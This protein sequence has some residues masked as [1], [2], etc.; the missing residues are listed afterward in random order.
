MEAHTQNPTTLRRAEDAAFRAPFASL[1]PAWVIQVVGTLVIATL[2]FG[3]VAAERDRGTVRTLA[4]AGVSARDLATG[5]LMASG[6]LV[7]GLTAAAVFTSVVAALGAGGVALPVGRML[8]LL[9]AYFAALLAFASLV[10]W[11]SARA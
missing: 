9:L 6:V 8:A 2:L 3:A 5:K 1:S 10:V 11:I 7:A 4:V